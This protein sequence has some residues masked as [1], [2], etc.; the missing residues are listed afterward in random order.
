VENVDG[1]G[2]SWQ[3]RGNDVLI[4]FCG[5]K[6]KKRISKVLDNGGLGFEQPPT[7]LFKALS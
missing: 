5:E 6:V 3:G 2:A 1:G 7:V 4:R